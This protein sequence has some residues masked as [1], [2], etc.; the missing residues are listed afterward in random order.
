MG[1]LA[2]LSN[3]LLPLRSRGDSVNLGEAAGE[4]AE[5]LVAAVKLRPAWVKGSSDSSCFRLR[6]LLAASVSLNLR[7]ASRLEVAPP[8]AA[9]WPPARS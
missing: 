9:A 3:F 6:R 7:R 4:A 2:L 1:I 5:A 8:G